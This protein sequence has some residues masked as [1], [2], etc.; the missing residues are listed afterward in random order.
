MTNEEL[1]KL[2]EKARW[3][4][5]PRDEGAKL[6]IK[7]CEELKKEKETNKLLTDAIRH[8]IKHDPGIH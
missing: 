6:V 5:W 3:S 8:P 2:I 1:A 4:G 7:L